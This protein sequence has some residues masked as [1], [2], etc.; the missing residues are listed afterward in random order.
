MP[1]DFDYSELLVSLTNCFS[2]PSIGRSM[3]EWI[4]SLWPLNVNSGLA[5]IT[6]KF[7]CFYLRPTVTDYRGLCWTLLPVWEI[8]LILTPYM[9]LVLSQLYGW[10]SGFNPGQACSHAIVYRA[11][12]TSYQLT[13]CK[14]ENCCQNAVSMPVVYMSVVLY[15]YCYTTL[16]S[17]KKRMV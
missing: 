6:S 5:S 4:S 11:I 16:C 13:Q 2:P 14:L 12:G 10:S 15:Y 3:V 9:L 17:P 1:T 7:C 8:N